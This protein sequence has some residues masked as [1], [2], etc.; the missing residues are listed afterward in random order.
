MALTSVLLLLPRVLWRYVIVPLWNIVLVGG[1]L[2]IAVVLLVG[3][4]LIPGREPDHYTDVFL[5]ADF[6]RPRRA[7]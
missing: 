5:P 1:L 7:P 3:I 4:L 2:I 6:S